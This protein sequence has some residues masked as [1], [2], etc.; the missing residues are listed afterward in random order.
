MVAAYT[1]NMDGEGAQQ[2]SR[3]S[4]SRLAL[5]SIWL[6]EFHNMVALIRKPRRLRVKN[7]LCREILQKNQKLRMTFDHSDRSYQSLPSSF[8]LIL[9][10][11]WHR[12]VAFLGLKRAIIF[13]RFEP[14]KDSSSQSIWRDALQKMETRYTA[15]CPPPPIDID[16]AQEAR[17]IPGKDRHMLVLRLCKELSLDCQALYSEYREKNWQRLHSEGQDVQEM[18]RQINE[19][20]ERY[21]SVKATYE[22]TVRVLALPRKD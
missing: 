11:W 20:L 13:N 19:I 12:T 6:M 14:D 7:N 8:M 22:N 15:I 17:Q 16:M 5:C 18:D 9:R 1:R 2:A 3:D 21:Q 10:R 4:S